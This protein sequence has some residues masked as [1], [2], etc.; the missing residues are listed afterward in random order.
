ML[1]VSVPGVSSWRSALPVLK[2]LGFGKVHL[3]FDADVRRNRNVARALSSAFR[4]LDEQ[5]FEVVL[6]TWSEENG[7]G[8]DDLLAGGHQPDL[9][10]GAE[11]RKTVNEIL[12]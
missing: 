7:K 12:A 4:A 2:A 11:A 6:E 5:G 9:K 1:T 3:A 8:I 10:V